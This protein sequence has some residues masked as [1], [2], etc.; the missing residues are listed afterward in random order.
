MDNTISYLGDD[1]EAMANTPRYVDWII[2]HFDPY[3]TGST[4]EIG[5]GIGTISDRIIDKVSS[6]DLIEP[7]ILQAEKLR[8][9]FGSEAKVNVIKSMLESHLSGQ[10][11]GQYDTVVMVNVLEHIENDKS[12]L[13]LIFDALKGGGHLL[14]YV[15]AMPFLYS[16]F[17][18]L[19]GHHRRYTRKGLAK[20]LNESGFLVKYNSYIDFFGIL[21]WYLINTIGGKTSLNSSA[22]KL[23]DSAGVPV[24][25]FAERIMTPPIGK[26]IIFIAEKPI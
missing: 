7:S 9:K 2:D 25:R 8:L 13:A 6:L 19:V 18:E 24:T 5:A 20:E 23:Y 1:L 21:P 3:L 4:A 16:K 26:N 22:V 14:L 12:A 17:D 11:P 10:S 15:P